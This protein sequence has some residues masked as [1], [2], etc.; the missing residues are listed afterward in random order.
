MRE[1]SRFNFDKVRPNNLIKNPKTRIDESIIVKPQEK[2]SETAQLQ[3]ETNVVSSEDALAVLESKTENNTKSF[4]EIYDEMCTKVPDRTSTIEEKQTALDYID[5]MLNAKDITP[6]LKSY[7]ENKKVVIQNE[8]KTIENEQKSAKGE[9]T[10]SFRDVFEEMGK[11]VPDSTSTLEE[12]ELA[13]SYINRML[14]CDDI[15]SGAKSFW[16]SQMNTIQKEI[17]N[18]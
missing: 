18:F 5:Q 1:I 7:W 14:S 15:P 16:T 4:Q 12:K 6:E 17:E 2:K 13:I 9:K 8:I 11:N 10:E 3:K